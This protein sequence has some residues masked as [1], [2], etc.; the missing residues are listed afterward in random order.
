M[1]NSDIEIKEEDRDTQYQLLGISK[2]EIG[3][4]REDQAL[5]LYSWSQSNMYHHEPLEYRQLEHLLFQ[6]T[7]IIFPLIFLVW[8]WFLFPS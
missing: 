4:P 5:L 6:H 1:C 3:K 8:E 2:Y 7:D